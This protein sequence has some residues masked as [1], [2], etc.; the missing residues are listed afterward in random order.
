[1]VLLEITVVL[2]SQRKYS[3]RNL[4]LTVISRGTLRNYILKEL[5]FR[6]NSLPVKIRAIKYVA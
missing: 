3:C 6:E 2:G 5:V 4:F 1:L